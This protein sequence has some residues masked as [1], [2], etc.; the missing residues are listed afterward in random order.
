MSYY[1]RGEQTERERRIERLEEYSNRLYEMQNTHGLRNE[2]TDIVN[3]VGDELLYNQLAEKHSKCIPTRAPR[4]ERQTRG[5]VCK[6]EKGEYYYSNFPNILYKRNP[7]PSNNGYM[8]GSPQAFANFANR[9][10][11]KIYKKQGLSMTG[12]MIILFTAIFYPIPVGALVGCFQLGFS[13]ASAIGGII[14]L[15]YVNLFISPILFGFIFLVFF[16]I[17]DYNRSP[18]ERRRAGRPPSSM[19]TT[20][21][22]REAASFW[23]K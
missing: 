5:Y 20:S 21:L 2:L 9:N 4:R 8:D 15:F 6:N 1:S 7:A 11:H 12:K 3:K 22:K 18:T 13:T 14:E 10:R 16:W 23:Q 19:I 17:N